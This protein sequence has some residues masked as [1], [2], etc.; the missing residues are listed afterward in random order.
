M[1]HNSQLKT[2]GNHKLQ[3]ENEFKNNPLE[4]KQAPW[5]S[6]LDKGSD[7]CGYNNKVKE[8]ESPEMVT[9]LNRGAEHK[10]RREKG[11]KRQGEKIFIWVTRYKQPR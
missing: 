3:P 5:L 2:K 11:G 6:W 4:K 7:A 10:A 8:N 1:N 9:A